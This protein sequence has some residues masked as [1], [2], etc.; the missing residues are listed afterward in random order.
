LKKTSGVFKDKLNLR[1]TFTEAL[2]EGY[3]KEISMPEVGEESEQL[4]LSAT[5]TER[6][7]AS[8]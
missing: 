4:S 8:Y 5:E 6:E 2:I 7:Q 3:Q 1:L